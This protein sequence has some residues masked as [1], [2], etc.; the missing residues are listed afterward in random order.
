MSNPT[1]PA[2]IYG[3]PGTLLK[4]LVSTNPTPLQVSTVYADSTGTFN[5]GV[6]NPNNAYCKE[7]DVA[8]PYGD[9]ADALFRTIPSVAVN[10]QYWALS[11]AKIVTGRELGLDTDTPYASFYLTCKDANYYKVDYNLAISVQGPVNGTTGDA[12]ILLQEIASATGTP[13]NWVTTPYSFPLTKTTPQFYLKNLIAASPANP[14]VPA[15][16]FVNG[17]GIMVA[18]ESNGTFYQLYQK[19]NATPIYSGIQTTFTLAGGLATDTTF[20]V[21]ATM[22]GNQAAGPD[23]Q[24]GYTPIFLY[25][26]ITV[27]ISNP[28]LTPKSI[29]ASG[30]IKAD[31]LN[32]TNSAT[33]SGNTTVE[34]TLKVLQDTTLAA[35]K[36]TSLNVTGTAGLGSTTVGNSLTVNGTAT[37]TD[38]LTAS[39]SATVNGLLTAGAANINGLLRALGQ[40]AVLGNPQTINPGTYTPPSDGFA[41]GYVGTPGDNGKFCRTIVSGSCAGVNATAQGGNVC[42][43][44]RWNGSSGTAWVGGN[45]NSFTLPVRKGVSFTVSVWNDGGNEA[46]AYTVFYWVP[47]GAGSLSALER[48]GD[49][50]LVMPVGDSSPVTQTI[51]RAPDMHDLDISDLIEVLDEIFGDRL[52]KEKRERLQHAV[53]RIVYWETKKQS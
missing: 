27:T 18:W 52:S 20:I 28:D 23:P 34:G 21:V 29:V 12:T 6:F 51:S 30:N 9:N 17:A 25:D 49:A 33:L 7:I 15:S 41:I 4:Y 48:E 42:S 36:A 50:E 53:R 40:V 14:T 8:I 47:I 45:Q 5:I 3:Q 39:K 2:A 43:Y 31:T 32:V 35:A 38:L 46:N 16:E 11:S 22:T 13:Y 37:V 24:A 10:S 1:I 19:N 44:F 26:T